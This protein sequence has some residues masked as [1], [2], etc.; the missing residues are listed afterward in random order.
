MQDPDTTPLAHTSGVVKP[1]KI[2]KVI[3]SELMIRWDDGH[4]GL[5]V[6]TSLRKNCPCASCRAEIEAREGII[7]LPVLQPGQYDLKAVEPVGAYA[8]QL[9][10]GDGHKTGIYSFDYLR[11]ICDCSACRHQT[12]E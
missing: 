2:R 5:H 6:L 10:W 8:L 12:G 4:E 3:P 1:I 9:V 11:R 7:A